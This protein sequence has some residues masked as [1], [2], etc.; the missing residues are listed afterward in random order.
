MEDCLILKSGLPVV[1]LSP[2]KKD[3]CLIL[4][5]VCLGGLTVTG[6]TGLTGKLAQSNIGRRKENGK[7]PTNR[8]SN[9]SHH[10][11]CQGRLRFR[12]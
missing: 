6:L 11:R 5:F 10:Y 2:L 1:P 3:R 12:P 8:L 4:L 7:G 9:Q